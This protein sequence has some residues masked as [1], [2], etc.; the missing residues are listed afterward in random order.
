MHAYSNLKFLGLALTNAHSFDFILNLNAN[1]LRLLQRNELII[2]GESTEQQLI[3]SLKYYKTRHL[4]VQKALNRLFVLT[5]NFQETRLDLLVLI[6]ELM[7]AHKLSQSV[8]LA[9]TSCI[10]NLT[11]QKLH[12]KPCIPS[13]ILTQ[14]INTVL[15]TMAHF[16][17]TYNLQKNCLLMLR[18]ETLLKSCVSAK[19]NNNSN[20]FG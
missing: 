5:R 4:F 14:I 16:P 18:N 10:F 12:L 8:Q 13:Y 17:N 7:H 1:R 20:I 15:N 9:A 3:S 6:I 11:W 2:T 19:L